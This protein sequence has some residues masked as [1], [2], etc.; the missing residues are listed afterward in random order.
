MY[1]V[2][3]KFRH[4]LT[5]ERTYIQRYQSLNDENFKA[6]VILRSLLKWKYLQTAKRRSNASEFKSKMKHFKWLLRISGHNFHSE[7]SM[8][9]ASTAAS[10]CVLNY[11]S[12]RERGREVYC[13]NSIV[14]LFKQQFNKIIAHIFWFQLVERTIQPRIYLTIISYRSFSQKNCNSQKKRNWKMSLWV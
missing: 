9:S 6:F 12:D 7:F 3:I 10:V 5:E 8:A 13:C 2:L 14:F 1:F 4:N 11:D